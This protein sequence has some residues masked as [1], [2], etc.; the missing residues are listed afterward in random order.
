M[1]FNSFAFLVVI[2]LLSSACSTPDNT[3]PPAALT[4]IDD[5][6]YVKKVWSKDVGD[7]INQN[8]IK[9]N[10]VV[11][12]GFVFT[13]D[14]AGEIHKV[15]IKNGRVAWKFA[16]GLSPFAGLSATKNGLL[17]TSFNG[18]VA[19][20]Q[21][22]D[23]EQLLLQWKVSVNSEIRTQAVTDAEQVFIRSVDG[24][25]TSLNATDGSTRW[26]VSKR[27]PALSLTG[28]SYPVIAD[29][30]VLSGSDNG[31]LIAYARDSGS[32]VWESSVSV[33]RGR[34]EIE[35][36][37]DLDGQFKV[38][39]G[40]IYISSF[41][42]DLAALTV[43][44]GQLLWTRKFSS[45]QAIELDSEALYITDDES[46]IWS[47]DR[48]TGSAFW[49]QDV[50]HHRKL[51]APRLFGDKLIVADLEGYVHWLNK[52]DGRQL[53]RISTKSNP[54]L[55]QPI[56]NGSIVIVLDASNQLTALSQ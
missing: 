17:V 31:K 30:L 46:N 56:V 6:Q 7:G 14:L 52:S 51:T 1:K 4:K 29:D 26:S 47:I 27:V 11:I 5:K 22:S 12:D 15:D 23:E 9:L 25:L 21:F 16:T 36:L 18:E 45:F 13:I 2:T 32:I 3:I 19:S 33:A 34:T 50:L 44:T 53:S 8:Y 39:D 48:R 54:Y 24:K 55:S 10:P 37:I 20:Y 38:S 43:K 42:G 35:R 41:Q 49:K 28:N 40:V